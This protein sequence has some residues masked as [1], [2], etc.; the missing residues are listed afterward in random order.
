MPRHDRGVHDLTVAAVLKKPV[1]PFL[2][3]FLPWVSESGVQPTAVSVYACLN[4]LTTA[5]RVQDRL[6]VFDVSVKM[7]FV[8]FV[9]VH[10]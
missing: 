3:D 9:W 2:H 5:V 6:V 8:Y 1:V 7:Y 10:L 4:T